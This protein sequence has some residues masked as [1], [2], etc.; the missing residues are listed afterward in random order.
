VGGGRVKISVVC[1]ESLTAPKRILPGKEQLHQKRLILSSK[2]MPYEINKNSL[3]FNL[4]NKNWS[5]RFFQNPFFLYF[6][7][8]IVMLSTANAIALLER[9]KRSHGTESKLFQATIYR[10]ALTTRCIRMLQ[11]IK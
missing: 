10:S 3:F 9:Q 4:R 5:T 8:L 2:S 7:Y 1:N 11:S 6:E